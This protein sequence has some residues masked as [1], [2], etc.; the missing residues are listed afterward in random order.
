MTEYIVSIDNEESSINADNLSITGRVN[1]V[2]CAAVVKLSS[3]AK[4]GV[5]AA[6]LVKQRALIQGFLDRQEGKTAAAVGEKVVL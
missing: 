1:G 2:H 6:K 3:V 5:K 4:L